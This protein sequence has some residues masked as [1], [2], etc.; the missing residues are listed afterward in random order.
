MKIYKYAPIKSAIKIID[1]ER[2]LLRNPLSFNDPFDTNVQRDKKDIIKVRKIMKDFTMETFVIRAAMEP[3]IASK[4]KQK[5]GFK[6]VRAEYAVMCKSLKIYPRYKGNFSMKSLYKMLSIKNETFKKQ[7][8]VNLDKFEKIANDSIERTKKDALATC[9]SKRNDSILMWSH[10]ADS[11]TGVCIEYE[12]P[13][14]Y[15]YVDVKYSHKRQ[16]IKLEEVVSYSCAKT[17]VGDDL[18]HQL[19]E[20]LM[21]ET[22]GPFLVKSNEWKYE[23]E[24]R[25]LITSGSKSSNYVV[26]NDKQYYKM[27]KPTKIYIGCR[28]KGKEMNELIK[29]A[30]KKNIKCVF[31]KCDNDTFSL[32]EK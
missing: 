22:I 28:A 25:C 16:K 32:K 12:R 3:N 21:L 18:N 7:I 8:E 24:V 27:P 6:M 9:F 14:S 17:I 26:E 20:K 10:Y 5:A 19:D 1:D 11:H 29:L 13:D 4:I 31:L 30:K 2:L 23:Q 15:D